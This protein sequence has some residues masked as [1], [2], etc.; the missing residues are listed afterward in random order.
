LTGADSQTDADRAGGNLAGVR[1]LRRTHRGHGV[2]HK[3]EYVAPRD[4]PRAL[5]TVKRLTNLSE[6]L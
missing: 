3:L 6:I 1:I 2:A 5:R 4:V